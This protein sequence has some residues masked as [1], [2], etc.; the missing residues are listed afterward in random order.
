MCG[1]CDGHRT[2]SQYINKVDTQPKRH[3]LSRDVHPAAQ[4]MAAMAR[5]ARRLVSDEK[6]VSFSDVLT[7]IEPPPPRTP[8]PRSMAGWEARGGAGGV[9]KVAPV[10]RRARTPRAPLVSAPDDE[11]GSPQ[12]PSSPQP[13]SG[14]SND[15][16]GTTNPAAAAAAAAAAIAAAPSAAAPAA[17]APSTVEEEEPPATGS[18]PEPSSP[19]WASHGASSASAELMRARGSHRGPKGRTPR[20]KTART[21]RS[22]GASKLVSSA[23]ADR[24]AANAR[25]QGRIAVQVGVASGLPRP[26]STTAVGASSGLTSS[27][28]YLPAGSSYLP[29]TRSFTA[30]AWVSSGRS[31]SARY[32]YEFYGKSSSAIDY[33]LSSPELLC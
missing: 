33:D 6:R 13:S 27:G 2:D 14:A 21:P 12:Q 18:E 32:G 7:F 29:A 11:P 20:A 24:A 4:M 15:R 22:P 1:D 19:S 10:K 26:G 3:N 5:S 16:P 28:G 23:A 30:E 31:A 25:S 8:I 17:G 9:G